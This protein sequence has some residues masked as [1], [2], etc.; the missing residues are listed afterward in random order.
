[1]KKHLMFH[2]YKIMIVQKILSHDPVQRLQF[3]EHMLN[4]LHDD[5]AVIVFSDEAH[6]RL[7][8]H[9]SKQICRYWAKETPR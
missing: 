3:S 2:S 9:V 5:L 7:D 4:I 8:A 1:M 6:F